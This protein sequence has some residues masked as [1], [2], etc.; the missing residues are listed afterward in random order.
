[1]SRE[2]RDLGAAVAD[3]LST[4]SESE[5]RESHATTGARV[6]LQ[7]PAHGASVHQ[8]E[9]GDFLLDHVG[10]LPCSPIL[11][12]GRF[13]ANRGGAQ[14]ARTPEPPQRS[15]VLA[16]ES[17]SRDRPPCR[18]EATPALSRRPDQGRSAVVQV[19]VADHHGPS[20][21][22]S[23]ENLARRLAR[24]V[25][26]TQRPHCIRGG[27]GNTED[28]HLIGGRLRKPALADLRCPIGEL[29]RHDQDLHDLPCVMLD[30][31]TLL[32]TISLAAATAIALGACSPVEKQVDPVGADELT[33]AVIERLE[34]EL[35]VPFDVQCEQELP[36]NVGATATCDVTSPATSVGDVTVLVTVTGVDSETGIVSFD[37]TAEP[38]AQPSEDEAEEP[39]TESEDESTS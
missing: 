11:R 9:P 25:R 24:H 33:A 7:R 28:R 22:E 15:G 19:P 1:M 13:V 21:S 5:Q 30:L 39:G 20:S 10:K 8:I 27:L 38:V 26:E 35:D 34:A 32:R 17:C 36:A 3:V 23:V 12:E 18:L 2:P 14:R 29:A 31:M 6:W 16:E 4:A 37:L